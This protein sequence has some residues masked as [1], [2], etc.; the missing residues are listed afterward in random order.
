MER[1]R[2]FLDEISAR[3]PD[4]I[5][6]AVSHENPIVAAFALTVDDPEKVIRDSVANCGW[7]ELDWPV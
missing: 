5:V 7:L 4:G 2:S 1:M 3:H 6:L